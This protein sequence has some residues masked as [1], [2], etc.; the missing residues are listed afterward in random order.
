MKKNN[1][2]TIMVHIISLTVLVSANSFGQSLFKAYT[3]TSQQDLA[4]ETQQMSEQIIKKF[5]PQSMASTQQKIYFYEYFSNLKKL[6]L[7]GTKLATYA[8]YEQDLAFAKKNEVFKGLPEKHAAGKTGNP[9]DFNRTGFVN[10]KYKMMQTNIKDEIDTYKDLIQSSLDS[11]E[12]LSLYDLNPSSMNAK[13]TDRIQYYFQ[14]S[15]SYKAYLEKQDKLAA[16]WPLLAQ[17][18]KKQTDMW[19]EK[20]LEPEDP[21]I[22][23]SIT[24]AISNDGAV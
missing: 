6:V 12:H 8:E 21:V 19:Q 13:N 14:T 23:R 17:R 18:I 16:A 11:C 3:E 4:Q 15:E 24:K 5:N 2:M 22:D 1:V 10:E 9:S 20:G 7:Y